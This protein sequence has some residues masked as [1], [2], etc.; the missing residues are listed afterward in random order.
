[1]KTWQMSL[2]FVLIIAQT[3]PKVDGHTDYALF[4]ATAIVWGIYL[5]IACYMFRNDK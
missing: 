3:T 2:L 4:F 1:M 5:A